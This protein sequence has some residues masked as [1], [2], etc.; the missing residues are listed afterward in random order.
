MNAAQMLINVSVDKAGN[1]NLAMQF[2]GDEQMLIPLLGGITQAQLWV[3][4]RLQKRIGEGEWTQP[5][6]M[7][8]QPASPAKVSIPVEQ[9]TEYSGEQKLPRDK[10]IDATLYAIKALE[11]RVDV[12]RKSPET[13]DFT[14]NPELLS[15]L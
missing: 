13:A 11:M 3:S 12:M 7:T 14:I 2:L 9:A 8:Q 6:A 5:A 1:H 15:K 4:N 10:A